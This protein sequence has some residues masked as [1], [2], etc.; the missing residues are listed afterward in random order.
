[1]A[2]G[3]VFYIT[4]QLHVDLSCVFFFTALCVRVTDRRDDRPSTAAVGASPGQ[5]VTE[6]SKA[7][8]E[9]SRVAN[10]FPHE[11]PNVPSTTEPKTRGVLVLY[12]YRI[13]LKPKPLTK[14][15]T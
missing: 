13:K 6:I 1:M 15:G 8:A 12:R 4:R 11:D 14:E 7:Q 3:V 5:D 9:L 2:H 10:D